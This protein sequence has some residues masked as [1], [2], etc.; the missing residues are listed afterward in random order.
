MA[1]TTCRKGEWLL[2][3]LPT[4][5]LMFLCLEQFSDDYDSLVDNQIPVDQKRYVIFEQGIRVDLIAD[6]SQVKLAR[7]TSLTGVD[8]NSVFSALQKEYESDAG[9]FSA[10][11]P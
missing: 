2:T 9:I 4:D 3:I 1:E 8:A 5:P 6:Q 11:R 7:A 10:R